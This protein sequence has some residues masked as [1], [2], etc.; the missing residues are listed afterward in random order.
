MVDE[1]VQQ[2]NLLVNLDG[3]SFVQH[4]APFLCSYY[5][6]FQGYEDI[7]Q[8]LL[9]S[10]LMNGHEKVVLCVAVED[11]STLVPLSYSA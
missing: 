7:T 11:S 5:L 8:G 10:R 3:K 1:V 6:T 9:N 2:F 4:E